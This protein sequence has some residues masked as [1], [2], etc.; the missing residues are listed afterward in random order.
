METEYFDYL[1]KMREVYKAWNGNV[2][3][4]YHFDPSAN[5]PT[6]FTENNMWSDIRQNG[7]PM[8]YQFPIGPYYADFCDPFY[9]LVVE[10]DGK[11]H[12]GRESYDKKRATYI[13]SIGF[14]VLRIP[15]R[16]TFDV[17]KETIDYDSGELRKWKECPAFLLIEEWYSCIGRELP[18]NRQ[19]IRSMPWLRFKKW[20]ESIGVKADKGA[21]DAQCAVYDRIEHAYKENGGW[22]SFERIQNLL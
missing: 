15:G 18:I 5:C 2:L 20:K 3:S 16:L 7:I 11:A 6:T 21:F 1:K 4:P 19:N 13:E 17:Q 22:L 14:D 10:I 8:Y 12:E 9:G